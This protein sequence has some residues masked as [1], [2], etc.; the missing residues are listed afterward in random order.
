MVEVRLEGGPFNGERVTISDQTWNFEMV[1][2]DGTITAEYWFG[3]FKE[4]EDMFASYVPKCPECGFD[5][6][7]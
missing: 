6:E 2:D 4:G 7:G 1:S 3:E 5:G